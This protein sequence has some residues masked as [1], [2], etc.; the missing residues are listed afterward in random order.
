MALSEGHMMSQVLD[1]VKVGLVATSCG[2]VAE[3]LIGSE[4]HG[5]LIPLVSGIAGLYLGPKLAVS[6]GWQWG[7]SVAGHLVVPIL[8]GAIIACLTVKLLTLA[9][10]STRR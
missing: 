7:P 8:L 10:A 6:M 1:V 4:R 2:W 3:H 9:F 5:W